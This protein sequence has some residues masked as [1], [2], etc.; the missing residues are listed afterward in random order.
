[1]NRTCRD[2]GN[3]IAFIT[4]IAV[5]DDHTPIPEVPVGIDTGRIGKFVVFSGGIDQIIKVTD[6]PNGGS[7][8]KG[9]VVKLAALWRS[10]LTVQ[11]S[12][13]FPLDGDHILFQFHHRTGQ[14]TWLCCLDLSD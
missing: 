8:I 10:G 11:H 6:L 3:G 1:M 5:G 2:F 13:G 14:N 4:Q 12:L 9:M 7:L